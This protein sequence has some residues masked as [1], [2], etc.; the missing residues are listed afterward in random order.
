MKYGKRRKKATHNNAVLVLGVCV[1]VNFT[2]FGYHKTSRKIV[3][4]NDIDRFRQILGA[5]IKM[6]RISSYKH[7]QWEIHVFE[8][9]V[10]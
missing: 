4:P 1:Y 8:A 5:S 2:E 9:V 3:Q 7:T 6:P 10:C